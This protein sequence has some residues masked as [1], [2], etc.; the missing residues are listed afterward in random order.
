MKDLKEI[1]TLFNTAHLEKEDC[2]KLIQLTE[3]VNEAVIQGYHAA[4]IMVSSKYLINPFKISNVFNQGKALLEDVISENFAEV[5][6][7]FLRYT[8]Q[9]NTP[10]FIGYYKS[11]EGDRDVLVKYILKNKDSELTNHMMVFLEN[12]K[13]EILKA[14]K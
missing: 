7:R 9:L 2:L 13:D 3:N 14:I 4:A 5:E 12:T 10:K 8:I 6:I 1:R 11:I